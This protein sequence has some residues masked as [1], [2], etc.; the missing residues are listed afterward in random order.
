MTVRE[1]F[2]DLNSKNI[3]RIVLKTIGKYSQD[4]VYFKDSDS[5]FIWVTESHARQVGAKNAADMIGKSDFDYFPKEFAQSAKDTEMTIMASGEAI[6]NM[7]EELVLDDETVRYFMASKYPLYD[8]NGDIIGTWGMSRDITDHLKLENELQESL[9]KLQRLARVDDLSG[10][11]NRRYFY[12]KLEKMSSYYSERQEEGNFSLIV[13]DVDDMTQV[14]DQYGQQN[15]DL[16]LRMIASVMLSNCRKPDTCFRTGGDEF[17]IILPGCEKVA[18]LGIAKRIV[19]AI[20]GTPVR[21]DGDVGKITVS[22]GVVTFD[23]NSDLEEFLSNAERKL[24]KSKRNGKN[25]ASI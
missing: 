18:A 19:D 3:E 14:N 10:L 2:M 6:V 8:D 7:T 5:R 20:A 12:E 24:N 22:A 17:A 23:K 16:F 25:Q 15:G 1:G 21:L 9:V 4:T 11:Y 13:I